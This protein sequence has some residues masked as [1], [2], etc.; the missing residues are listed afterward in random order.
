MG[1]SCY[2]LNIIALIVGRRSNVG[3]VLIEL[4]HSYTYCDVQELFE[5]RYFVEF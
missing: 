5:F 3:M 4:D 1:I 2:V